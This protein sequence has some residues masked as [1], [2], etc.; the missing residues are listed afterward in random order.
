M[1]NKNKIYKELKSFITKDNIDS[2]ISFLF[3]INELRIDLKS[4]IERTF[5]TNSTYTRKIELISKYLIYRCNINET[6]N[7]YFYR[8]NL[9]K[10]IGMLHDK[11]KN[12]EIN[13]EYINW[14]DKDNDVQKYWLI[15]ELINLDNK[16]SFEL[17]FPINGIIL[18]NKKLY[19]KLF[20][21]DNILYLHNQWGH[22]NYTLEKLSWLN[23]D[24]KKMITWFINYLNQRPK[25]TTDF[26]INHCNLTIEKRSTISLYDEFIALKYLLTSFLNEIK[27]NSS[28]D[29]EVKKV[30]SA[31]LTYKRRNNKECSIYM[32][33]KPKTR[34]EFRKF[35][36]DFNSTESEGIDFL[37][38]IY[39][40]N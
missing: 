15:N 36:K 20:D 38:E 40:E 12:Y 1:D 4:D 31:W 26:A 19:F 22:F 8:K 30:R 34:N 13:K 33:L 35:M 17:Y 2:I 21:L 29:F 32:H 9:N 37:L 25:I 18:P 14:I 16:K 28:F 7:E 11:V 10:E 27:D 23:S 3:S 5:Y 6:R 39:N 24:D